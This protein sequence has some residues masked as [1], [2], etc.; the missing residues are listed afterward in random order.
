MTR[1]L[2][3]LSDSTRLL[4]SAAI[5]LAV[6]SFVFLS[7]ASPAD[8]FDINVDR[9]PAGVIQGTDIDVTVE[10]VVPS[11]ERLPIADI[12]VSAS[13]PTPFSV[14]FSTTGVINSSSG[15][16]ASVTQ[17]STAEFGS[18]NRNVT[19]PTNTAF[20]FGFGYGFGPA[21]AG[22]S[23]TLKY[24]ITLNTGA[25]EPGIYTVRATVNTGESSKPSFTSLPIN[26]FIDA[27]PAPSATATPLPDLEITLSEDVTSIP[28]P[29][30]GDVVILQPD[31]PAQLDVPDKGVKV[32]IP[33]AVTSKTVQ[34]QVTS[35]DPQELESPPQ[36][37][38]FS[39]IQVDVFDTQGDQVDGLSLFRPA[40]VT[41]TLNDGHVN[42][43]GGLSQIG[44][45][46]V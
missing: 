32:N 2:L 20:S 18:G 14:N 42:A 8:A 3:G 34:I 12:T 28:E 27:V 10:V 37:T 36:G 45:A 25:M 35:P 38:T 30:G 44:R 46:H 21:G 33:S 19:D 4:I 23:T 5:S 40:T 41:V 31:A 24:T 16:V 15:P 11:G 43:L 7:T 1:G 9:S 26:F 6:I 13:A 17:T 29:A 22:S 39:V